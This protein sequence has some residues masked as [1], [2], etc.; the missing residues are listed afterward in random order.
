MKK[1]IRF[2]KAFLFCTIL[3]VLVIASGIFVVATKGLNFGID[4]RPGLVEEIKIAPAEIELTY[5]GSANVNVQ[6][7][8][9]AVSLVVSGLGAD[10]STYTFSFVDYPTVADLANAFNT[11]PEVS[12]KL[13]SDGTTIAVLPTPGSPIKQGLFLLLRHKI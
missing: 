5:A 7:S 6:I 13:L 8:S 1:I 11:V 3:S 10:N 9:Q 2:S 12:S 4:F